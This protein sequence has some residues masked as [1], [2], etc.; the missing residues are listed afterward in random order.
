MKFKSLIIIGVLTFFLCSSAQA[1]WLTKDAFM[2][3]Y[4]S[5]FINGFPDENLSRRAVMEHWCNAITDPSI[6]TNLITP[7]NKKSTIE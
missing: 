3:Q 2:Q 7:E 4:G 5:K 6:P 1:V